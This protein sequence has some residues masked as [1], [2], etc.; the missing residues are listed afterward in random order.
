MYY[1]IPYPVLLKAIDLPTYSSLYVKHNELVYDLMPNPEHKSI[2]S[3]RVLVST[4]DK[5][6][7]TYIVYFKELTT[8][9]KFRLMFNM[10]NFKLTMRTGRKTKFIRYRS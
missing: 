8:A 5:I 10:D 1:L 7:H 3:S 6:E 9:I 4:I 2:I